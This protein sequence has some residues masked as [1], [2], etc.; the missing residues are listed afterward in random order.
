MAVTDP[1]LLW[2][3]DRATGITALV[4]LTLVLALG[5]LS[6]GR[7]P[8][9]AA[10]RALV[11]GVHREL[12]LVAV[13][14]LVVHI[15]TAVVDPHVHLRPLDVVVPFRASWEPLAVGLGAVA[16]DV[17]VV[18]VVTSLVRRRL[19]LR[20]WRATHVL[21]YILWPA[22]VLHAL[23]IGTDTSVPGLRL[24]GVGCLAVVAAAVVRRVSLVVR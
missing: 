18:L 5:V 4:L 21:A 11:Q 17:L 16:V 20:L 15:T 22:A 19:P 3:V 7:P 9:L 13:L 12:P 24:F 23:A 6:V 10:A 14:L 1:R 8:R 2:W